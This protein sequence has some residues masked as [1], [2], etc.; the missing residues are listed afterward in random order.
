MRP[1]PE[2]IH[3]SSQNDLRKLTHSAAQV[4]AGDPPPLLQQ[5]GISSHQLHRVLEITYEAAWFMSHRIREAMRTDS[6]S[7][8]GG[9]GSIFE[10]D[11]TFLGTKEGAEKKPRLRTQDGGS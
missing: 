4:V 2:A 10:S 5:E 6:L 7:P 1:L 3:G 8:M 9:A 11:E